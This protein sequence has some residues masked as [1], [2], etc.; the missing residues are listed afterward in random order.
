MPWSQTTPMDQKTQFIAEYLRQHRSFSDLCAAYGISRKT[1]Y[2]WVHRYEAGGPSGLEE[3]SRRPR[4]SPGQ[5]P[6]AVVA[7]LLASRRRHPTWGAKKI[8]ALLSRQHPDWPLP[9]RATVCELFQR[10]GLVPRQRRRRRLGHPGRPRTV[11]T[12]PNDLWA[13][14]F[15]GE[16]K[17]GNGRYCYPLTITDDA[18]RYLLAC[19]GLAAT[20]GAPAKQ[21]FT[22]VFEEYGLPERI[23]SDNGVPFASQALG[24][25][26]RLSVWW[27]RLGIELER[28]EPG[29]PQQNGRHERMHKTLKAEATRP[30]AHSLGPQQRRFDAFRQEFNE[31]RP[32]EAL[33]Q[34]TP[35]SHYRVSRRALPRHLPPF[36][37]PAHFETRRVC[38]NG[39]IR[40][41][42]HWVSVSSVCVREQVGMEEVEDG[43]WDVFLGSLKLGLLQERHMQIEDAYGR[44]KRVR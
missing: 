44:L 28:I 37:Y 34:Q 35:A 6:G 21:V 24:R 42:Q 4:S 15:K 31:V 1:G 39:C 2:K 41:R 22:R 26:S 40:W 36:E 5:T 16:F 3:H 12:E 14:D 33:A 7:A 23:R 20:A 13:V 8:L 17:L 43:V 19:Q 27:L 11:V 29:R 9:H 38:G 30:P 10:H 32:H 18:S 25:L